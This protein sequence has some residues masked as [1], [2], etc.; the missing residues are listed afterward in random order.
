MQLETQQLD[1]TWV[2]MG[3]S[4]DMS[5]L[6]G[7]IIV[8][9]PVAPKP[10]QQCEQMQLD[11]LDRVQVFWDVSASVFLSESGWVF[12]SNCTK[13]E[14]DGPFLDQPLHHCKKHSNTLRTSQ[15]ELARI[16]QHQLLF[17]NHLYIMSICHIYN[18]HYLFTVYYYYYLIHCILDI[19]KKSCDV[20]C[21]YILAVALWT[22]K[23]CM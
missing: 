16:A 21:K 6:F 4:R 20:I 12:M 7:T 8:S 17:W 15:S 9:W 1:S 11:Y 5:K 13:P 22:S 3:C 2:Y 10:T 19:S 18:V 23:P 14:H